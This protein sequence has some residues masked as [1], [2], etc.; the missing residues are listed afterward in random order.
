VVTAPDIT[1]GYPSGGALVG[2]AWETIWNALGDGRERSTAQLA[3]LVAAS[4]K[5][6]ST[7]NLLYK[8]RQAGLIV[9]RPAPDVVHSRRPTLWRRVDTDRMPRDDV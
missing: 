7:A 3:A 9:S 1:K 4:I 6:K 2:P 8:A 5:P